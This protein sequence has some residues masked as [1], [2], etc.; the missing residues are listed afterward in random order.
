MRHAK[1]VPQHDLYSLPGRFSAPAPN[2]EHWSPGRVAPLDLIEEHLTYNYRTPQ[3]SGKLLQGWRVPC[4][5]VVGDHPVPVLKIQPFAAGGY[6]ASVRMLD[7]KKIGDA[8]NGNRR[9]GK[10]EVPEEIDQE[11]VHKAACRAKRRVRQL[12]KN[13]GATNLVTLTKREIDLEASWSPDDWAKAWDKARR[14]L[15]RIIGEFPYVGVLERH[16]KGNFH[17]HLAWVG[18]VNLG[19]FRR[20]WWQCCGGRGQGN[21]DSQYIRVRAGLERADRVAK[22][23]SKYTTKHFEDSGRFNK[24]RYWASK[25]TLQ[26]ARRFVL[27]AATAEGGVSEAIRLLGIDLAKFMVD[28]NGTFE[29]DHIFYFPD[30]SGAW[31]NFIPDIHHSTDIPF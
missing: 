11:H 3:Q 7:I 21:V 22:Y 31:I 5:F 26:E 30:G 6:E 19:L 28:R 1:Y 25:Q 10:R 17:L 16:K 29:L 27:K 20:V 14:M 15:T 8:M 9:V 4:D 12:V 2:A 24:K 18:K 23:I 13:M